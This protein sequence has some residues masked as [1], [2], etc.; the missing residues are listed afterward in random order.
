MKS[1]KRLS[2]QFLINIILSGIAIIIS[3]GSAFG[4]FESHQITEK[5]PNIILFLVGLLIIN[6][7]LERKNR[8]IILEEKLDKLNEIISEDNLDKLKRITND[9]QPTLR[10]IFKDYIQEFVDFF[11]D[12]IKNDKIDFYDMERFKISYMRT[13][14]L[15]QNKGN[16]LLATSLPYVRYFWSE[17]EELSPM[18]KSIKDFIANGGKFKRI[19][20]YELNDLNDMEV[21]NVLNGQIDMGIEVYIV[22]IDKVPRRLQ[23]YFVVDEGGN[24]AWNVSIDTK[25]RINS[26]SFTASHTETDKYLN[27]FNEI[28]NLD[29]LKKY[30]R[31]DVEE[32]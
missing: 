3:V 21:L 16:V 30:T 25:Q 23:K 13:L 19:F 7:T 10:H 26:M 28:L 4:L 14:E 27:Y 22:P 11:H 1:K 24:L 8:L 20:F 17:S 18:L 5:I 29:D 12:A 32:V 31:I 6:G 15:E 2:I 9:I